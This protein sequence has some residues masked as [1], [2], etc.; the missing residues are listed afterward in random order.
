MNIFLSFLL[1]SHQSPKRLKANISA[2]RSMNL[3]FP[4]NISVALFEHDSFEQQNIQ[5][6]TDNEATYFV[7]QA[8]THSVALNL[9]ASAS[10]GRYLLG[11]ADDVEMLTDSK[12]EWA[13]TLCELSEKHTDDVFALFGSDPTRRPIVPKRIVDIIG[14]LRC[15]IFCDQ[16]WSDRWMGSIV[17]Q[18]GRYYVNDDLRMTVDRELADPFWFSPANEKNRLDEQVVYKHTMTCRKAIA[19]VLSSHLV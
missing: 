2:I 12:L 14:Y 10:S 15:P 4:F 11:L 7:L 16:D 8:C 19:E 3:P 1:S 18:L 13:R 6:A 17:E 5:I 9:L